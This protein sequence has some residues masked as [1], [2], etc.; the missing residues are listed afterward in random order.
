M[1]VTVVDLDLRVRVTVVDLDL[2][3]TLIAGPRFEGNSDGWTSI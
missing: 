2:R 3:V 1:R